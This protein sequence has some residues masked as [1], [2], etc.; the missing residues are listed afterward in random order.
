MSI[1]I[2]KSSKVIMQGITGHHGSFHS[3]L[4]LNYGTKIVAGVTPGKEGQ[5]VHGIP[6]YSSVKNALKEHDAQWSIL[7]VPAEHTLEAG[8]EAV[9]AE[10]HLVIITEHMPV[11]D[12]IE[13][14]TTAEKKSLHVIGPNCPGIITV[15]ES[16]IGIMPT[17]IFSKGTIGVVS[18]SGTLT[19]EIVA[20]LTKAS[21][22]QSTVVGI[23]GD[24]VIG[25]TFVEIL[26][27]FEQDQ[28]TEKIVLIGE[29]GGNLEEK[30]ASYIK[31]NISKPIVAYIAGRNAPLGK[32]MGHAGAV[33]A[34]TRGTASSKIEALRSAGVKIADLPSQ[35][36]KLMQA[37]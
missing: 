10:L 33:I 6:V 23:G 2:N 24:R 32:I 14:I 34:G 3:K 25:S 27:L 8:L 29:I 9:A 17:H 12:A 30:A 19:Y 1:L 16:K 21:L 4:M 20:Q 37:H 11:L 26:E 18:R 36:V 13:L 35:V 7:F 28:E 31:N 22:G 15:G 5:S